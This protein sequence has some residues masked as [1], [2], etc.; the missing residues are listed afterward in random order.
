[1][2]KDFLK[3]IIPF[4]FFIQF[5]FKTIYEVV[6]VLNGLTKLQ[7]VQPEL[8]GILRMIRSFITCNCIMRKAP[9]L[10]CCKERNLYTSTLMFSTAGDARKKLI[11]TY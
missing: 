8:N 2:K 6:S 7:H 11:A 10:F 5:S 3:N 9:V 4:S 1:M